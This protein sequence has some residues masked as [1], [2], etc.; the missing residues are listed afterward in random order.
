MDRA[1][2]SLPAT[3]L[4][5]LHPVPEPLGCEWPGKPTLATTFPIRKKLLLGTEML[6]V[7]KSERLCLTGRA[8]FFDAE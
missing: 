4:S 5:H 2:A 6:S 1:A 7:R 3:G 8:A